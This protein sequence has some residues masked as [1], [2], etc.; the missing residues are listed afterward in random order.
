MTKV[1]KNNRLFLNPSSDF[2]NEM[3]KVKA[4]HLLEVIYFFF[5][6]RILWHFNFT[7]FYAK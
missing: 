3:K 5:L 7:Q 1:S 4:S 6:D 2:K